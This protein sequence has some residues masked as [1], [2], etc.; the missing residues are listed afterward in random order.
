V[1]PERETKCALSVVYHFLHEHPTSLFIC[2]AHIIFGTG[3][4]RHLKGGCG[5]W[6]SR[7]ILQITTE[8][9]YRLLAEITRD[10]IFI[11]CP[12]A[13]AT[14]H[15]SAVRASCLFWIVRVREVFG[16]PGKPT[17]WETLVSIIN[18]YEVR[19]PRSRTSRKKIERRF[20]IYH[21]ICRIFCVKPC[22]GR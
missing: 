16:I 3:G 6:A 5:R 9:N 21:E 11:R 22:D 14:L 15:K 1:E 10:D 8:P 18:P 19:H 17:F 20:R 7:G 2:L 4:F 13:L 12:D